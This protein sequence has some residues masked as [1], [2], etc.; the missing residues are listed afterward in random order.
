MKVERGVHKRC[1]SEYL[2]GTNF[3]FTCPEG[4]TQIE[5]M[6]KNKVKVKRLTEAQCR[7]MASW[8]KKGGV[9]TICKECTKINGA[10]SQV[11]R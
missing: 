4:H 5:D 2:G 8:W 1:K 11:C 7:L 3:R 6:S 10:S 9:T